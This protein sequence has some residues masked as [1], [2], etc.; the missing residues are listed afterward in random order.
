MLVSDPV[1]VLHSVVLL[2]DPVQEGR[3]F[4]VRTRQVKCL[5]LVIADRI[6]LCSERG[7]PGKIAV[8]IRVALRW[9]FL[10]FHAVSKFVPE[11]L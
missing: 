6:C 4:W 9:R 7:R 3:L 8:L 11:R 5:R 1:L 10:R 2:V